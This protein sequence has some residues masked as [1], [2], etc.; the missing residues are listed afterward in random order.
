MV[1]GPRWIESFASS[2]LKTS[3]GIMYAQEGNLDCGP[4]AQLVVLCTYED[5]YACVM[6]GSRVRVSEG[7]AFSLIDLIDLIL[8]L[9]PAVYIVPKNNR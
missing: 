7:P 3:S 8:L 9:F 1:L 5:I 2:R 4:L 6:Q